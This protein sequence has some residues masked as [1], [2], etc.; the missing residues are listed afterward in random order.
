MRYS[1]DFLRENIKLLEMLAHGVG[2]P[3]VFLAIQGIKRII[4]FDIFI[5]NTFTIN[6][7]GHTK[8]EENVETVR[9]V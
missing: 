5:Y 6:M 8:L 3:Q 4:C 2:L 9:I 7:R 1:D